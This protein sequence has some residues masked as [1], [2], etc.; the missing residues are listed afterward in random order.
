MAKFNPY[1]TWA[2]DG[3]ALS[4][5]KEVPLHSCSECHKKFNTTMELIRNGKCEKCAKEAAQKDN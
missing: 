3:K 5:W 2:N 4:Q 1:R